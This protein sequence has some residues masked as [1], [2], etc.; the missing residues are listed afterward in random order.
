MTRPSFCVD[1]LDKFGLWFSSEQLVA[2]ACIDENLG[3]GIICVQD[4]NKY[5]LDEMVEYAKENLHKNKSLTF[6]VPD[7]DKTYQQAVAKAGFRPTQERDTDSIIQIDMEN[8]RYTLPEGF[9]IT[10]MAH[11]YDPF[12][13][14]RIMHRGFSGDLVERTRTLTDIEYVDR[15]FKRPFTNL[16]LQIAVIAPDK[17]WAAFCG[18]WQTKESREAFIEPVVTDPSYQ[19]MGLGKAAVYEALFRC[20]KSGAESAVVFSSK[21]FYFSIGFRPNSTSTWWENI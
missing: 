11:N 18:M 10:D 12:Q 3:N 6:L 17:T 15:Q 19:K 21:Q 14:D 1:N 2:L 8:L 9:H 20:G 13:F 5:L 4:D 16:D 7:L